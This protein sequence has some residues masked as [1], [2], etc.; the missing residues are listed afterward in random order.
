MKD[1]TGYTP[2][3]L[4]GLTWD[5]FV[6]KEDEDLVKKLFVGAMGG[7]TENSRLAILNKAGDRIELSVKVIPL[8]IDGKVRG[9]Y[10]ILRDITDTLIAQKKL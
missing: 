9:V 3:E 8:I 10:G 5:S 4:I 7:T 6:A 1:V 2:S